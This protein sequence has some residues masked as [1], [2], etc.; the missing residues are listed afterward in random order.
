ME[1]VSVQKAPSPRWNRPAF[2]A[3]ASE[4]VSALH[5]V[6]AHVRLLGHS[7]AS[8]RYRY[9]MPFPTVAFALLLQFIVFPNSEAPFLFFYP[10]VM[11]AAWNGGFGP[12]T[13]TTIL[14]ALAADYFLLE[15]RH[16]FEIVNF[17]HGIALVLFTMIGVTISLMGE[18]IR[19]ALG[20]EKQAKEK[21]RR[22]NRALVALSNCNQVMIR[23]TD[24]TSLLQQICRLVVDRA[25]YRLCWV[26]YAEH[27]ESKTVRLVG[28]AGVDEGYLKMVNITWA[29]TERGRGPTGTCIRTQR[30]CLIR[31]T[32][33]DPRFVPWRAEALKRGYAS[34]VAIPLIADS[35]VY[36]AL[37][38]YAAEADA[39]GDEELML[40]TEMADD[41]AFGI[42]SLRTKD[43]RKK[44]V[45]IAAKH[46]EETKI[47][48]DIQQTILL[49]PLPAGVPGLE[50]AAVTVPSQQIDGD[51]YQFYKHDN[52]HLDFVIA[53]VMGKGI[54][55][56]LLGA[57]A[58]SHF[59]KALCHLNSCCSV[60]EL[61]EPKQIV[62]L[63]DGQMA[64]RLLE[65]ES[66]ITLCYV[67]LDLATHQLALV[68]CGHTG[69]IHWHAATGRCE[70]IHGD[71]LAL[72]MREGE[73]YEQLEIPFVPGDLFVL[74]SDG[75]TEARSPTKELFG[76]ARLLECVQAN[77]QRAPEEVVQ[78]I[79]QAV[80]SFAG[81]DS[82]SDDLTCLAARPVPFE[83][84]LAHAELE[85]K[86]D[87]KELPHARQFVRSV[88]SLPGQ[89]SVSEDFIDRLELAV[90]E[91]CSNVIKHAYHRRTDQC[92]QME[93]DIFPG[94]V[95]IRLH[96]LGPSFDPAKVEPPAFNGSRES[97]FGLY[98][99]QECVDRV[100]YYRD[101]NG[102]NCIALEKSR[103]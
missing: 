73:I 6:T 55:A 31:D 71:N 100:R 92:I 95:T 3:H 96:Y 65:V 83:A 32:A 48:W 76:T 34:C 84:P 103:S 11:L 53:D 14:S 87:L 36:G 78:A 42:G 8:R 72:G 93:A 50:I 58:K 54:P 21:F 17:A 40:L 24:E 80:V 57:A 44:A 29:D 19:T 51:F 66:F 38:I 67:R 82:L 33:A 56:A 68:D 37:S 20:A 89:N 64:Q 52:L 98:L 5:G 26:G 79:R 69:L 39:F 75:V 70:I 2:A 18:R 4:M 7:L 47:A 62:A 27:D 101:E 74:Y 10:A 25:G 28:H 99:I 97:G 12:G 46:E 43:E 1:N 35:E 23:A 61:P 45:E 102:R 41:L 49:D 88:C 59:L 94:K 16:S 90:T 77:C 60:G 13:V 85:L 22:T 63:V 30:A 9:A 86:S 15:P 91:A 81:S